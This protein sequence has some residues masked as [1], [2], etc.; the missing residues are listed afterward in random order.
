MAIKTLI[1]TRSLFACAH[2]ER[3]TLPSCESMGAYNALLQ[4]H[5]CRLMRVTHFLPIG[6]LTFSGGQEAHYGV[7]LAY[8]SSLTF[9]LYNPPSRAI[10]M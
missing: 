4:A 9:V 3:A 10:F 2:G 1:A 5:I 8:I 6:I 7:L